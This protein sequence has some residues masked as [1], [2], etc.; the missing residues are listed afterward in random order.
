M[1]IIFKVTVII[2]SLLFFN[3]SFAAVQTVQTVRGK[4]REILIP[5]GEIRLEGAKS[6]GT[7]RMEGSLAHNLPILSVFTLPAGSASQKALYNEMLAL[8]TVAKF[9]GVP[10][11]L[12]ITYDAATS[13]DRCTIVQVS[14]E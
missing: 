2:S 14:I 13:Q 10:V 3:L 12:T 4:V 8:L 6:I 9:N 7:C 11:T 1:K 5:N